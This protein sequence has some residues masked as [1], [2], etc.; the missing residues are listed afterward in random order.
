MLQRRVDHSGQQTQRHS[1]G[2]LDQKVVGSGLH[3]LYRNRGVY[4]AS[5]KDT[6]QVTGLSLDLNP[7][8]IRQAGV[9]Q[10][11]I[12]SPPIQ[13]RDS[14]CHGRCEYQAIGKLLPLHQPLDGPTVRIVIL[15]QQ[16]ADSLFLHRRSS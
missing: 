15:H 9:Y 8:T 11:Q 1:F 10:G 16:D 4:L 14:L 3:R 6:G 12:E 5:D 2:V 7:R 13:G